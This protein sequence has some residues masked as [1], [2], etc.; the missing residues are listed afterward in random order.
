MSA[1]VGASCHVD[2]LQMTK[3]RLLGLKCIFVLTIILSAAAVLHV[4]GTRDAL[5]GTES[6]AESIMT[7]LLFSLPAL[8]VYMLVPWSM[9]SIVVEG[10]LLGTLFFITWWS[11]ATDTHS[12][13]SFGPGVAGW[14][15]APF[16]I[17]AFGLVTALT[18]WLARRSEQEG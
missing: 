11:S 10:A 15:F 17:I 13:A 18:R 2:R 14:V 3:Q 16:I 8:A 9:S 1:S 7:V 5:L 12:T 6:F 4:R